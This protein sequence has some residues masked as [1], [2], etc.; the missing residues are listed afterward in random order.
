MNSHSAKGHYIQRA[1]PTVINHILF[2]IAHYIIHIDF[3]PVARAEN[4]RICCNV[5]SPR[6]PRI[7]NKQVCYADL[8]RLMES[9]NVHIKWIPSHPISS[10]LLTKWKAL[11]ANYSI[12]WVTGSLH[13]MW[14]NYYPQIRSPSL[15]HD[16]CIEVTYLFRCVYTWHAWWKHENTW[17]H[18]INSF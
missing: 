15:I 1:R 18:M 7:F 14:W 17:Y 8:K 11:I 12:N 4:S 10:R 5:L 9:L 6:W 3:N 2:L 16:T 13:I